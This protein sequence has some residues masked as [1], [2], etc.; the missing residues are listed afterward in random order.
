MQFRHISSRPTARISQRKRS[1]HPADLGDDWGGFLTGSS[2][3][4]LPVQIA[5]EHLDRLY[6]PFIQHPLHELAAYVN[7]EEAQLG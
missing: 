3:L 7:A 5:Y 2:E 1:T 4:F 6:Q